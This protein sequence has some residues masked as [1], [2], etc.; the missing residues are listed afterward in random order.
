[1]PSTQRRLLV[2]LIAAVWGSGLAVAFMSR[3]GYYSDFLAFWYA[4]RA[5]LQGLDP[6]AVTPSVAPYFVGDRF[7]YPLPSLLPIVP[8]A[9]LPLTLAGALFF[10]VSSG[11]LAYAITRDGYARLPLFVSFPFVMAA[12]LGQWAPLIMAAILLPGTGML[13]VCKP[14]LGLALAFAR[15]TRAAIYGGAALL[16]GSLA[17]DPAWP[18]KW[19]ANL[20]SIEGHPP[21]ILTL[22]GAFLLLALFR[23]RREDGRLV[24][25]MAA[26]PQLPMFADQL[27]LMLVAKTRVE[28][29]IL[30]LLSHVGGIVWLK[31]R[32][33]DD[34][35]STSAALY[36]L[37]FAYL[38]ALALVLG[39][40]NEGT[41][42]DW[43]GRL[44]FRLANPAQDLAERRTLAVHEQPGSIDPRG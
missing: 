12:S 17:F 21:P 7:F 22:L 32:S 28:S 35:P 19:L 27:P 23:W 34:H 33:P 9:H 2:A 38:P 43:L 11:L 39:R 8:F 6:Y 24:L 20:G 29:M 13:A 40:P 42:R 18:K 5:W 1:M 3:R 4:A 10:G 36:V 15:P 14:N 44:S 26:V 37:A 30:A 41:I 25:G 31:T 16:L